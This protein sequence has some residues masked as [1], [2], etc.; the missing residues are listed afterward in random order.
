[1]T[2]FNNKLLVYIVIVNYNNW[3]DTIECLESVFRNNYP[4]YRVL[5]IDNNSGDDSVARISAWAGGERTSWAGEDCRFP[6]LSQNPVSKPMSYSILTREEAEKNEEADVSVKPDC[7][8]TIIQ[9]GENLGFA[10]G[11]NIG[12][13]YALDRDDF[14]YIWLL[15]NDTVIEENAL[16]CLVESAE[17]YKREHKRVGIIGSKL[18]YYD[19][20]G[21]LQGIGGRYNKWF[22]LSQ[23]IGVF[24]EDKGQYDRKEVRMD[25]VIGASMFLSKT[26][27]EDVGLMSERY[28]L[29]FEDT[30][31]S[32]RA[33]KRDWELSYCFRSRVFHKEGKT[34][35]TSSYSD[36]RGRDADFYS[37]R[38]RIVF[39]RRFYPYA[40]PFVIIGVMVSIMLRI[41]RGQFD[42]ISVIYTACIEG[43]KSVA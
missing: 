9:A 31:L 40:I 24:E 28:F 6:N 3:Q 34:I 1:M 29:Y 43:M 36:K 42:R 15:N 11:N 38:S 30:D 27:L 23:H 37:T 10:G 14:E 17:D 5:V 8:L 20:P 19:K 2:T 7:P 13:R 18:L 22:A 32:L 16:K 39:T 41:K 26:F 4:H 12:I 21:I 33:K 35:G 25:Y